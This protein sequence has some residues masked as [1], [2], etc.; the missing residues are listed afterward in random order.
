MKDWDKELD[1]EIEA[2][3]SW[4]ERFGGF[5]RD[6][7]LRDYFAAKAMQGLIA[8][9]STGAFNFESCP[10]D[11]WRVALWAY[12]VADQMLEARKT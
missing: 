4:K 2:Y 11:P 9:E 7:T 8:R 5:S 12:D 1:K 10:N 6:M 3:K